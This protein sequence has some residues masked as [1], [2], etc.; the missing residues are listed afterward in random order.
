MV[1]GNHHVTHV[2]HDAVVAQRLMGI[3]IIIM[4]SNLSVYFL[5]KQTNTILEIK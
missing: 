1:H 2:G 3:V 4:I 5:T